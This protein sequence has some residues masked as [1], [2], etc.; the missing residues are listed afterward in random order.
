[1]TLL[2]I[3]W[4]RWLGLAIGSLNV[5]LLSALNPVSAAEQIRLSYGIFERTVSIDALETYAKTG[6]I[7]QELSSYTENLTPIQLAQFR[8]ILTNRIPLTSVE[9]SQFLYS[10]IGQ[11]LLNRLAAIIETDADESGFYGIR[12]ALILAAAD[13][14]GLTLLNILRKFPLPELEVDLARGQG[15]AQAIEI[16]VSQTNQAVA[17]INQQAA[18][19]PEPLPS[20]ATTDLQQSGPARWQQETIVLEDQSR[21]R[22][23]PVDLYLPLTTTSR[24][25]PHPVIVISHG[26]GSDR[27]SFAYLAQHLASYGFVVAVPEHPGSSAAQLQALLAGSANQVTLPSEFIDRPLDISYLLDELSHLANRDPTW[28]GRLNLE[29]VGVIGQSFGGYTALALAGAPLQLEQLETDCQNLE[30]SLNASLLLQCVALG[31]PRTQYDLSDPRIKAAIAIN[32]VDSS[33]LGEVGLSQIDIPVMIVSGSDDT[34][35]PALSEQ[36]QPFSWLTT[37]NK[38]LLLINNATHFSAISESP[39]A[40][41]RVPQ[42]VIGPRPSVV[43]N[44]MQA[45]S[46]AFAKNHVANQPEYSSY[47]SNAYA[48]AIDETPLELSLVQSLPALLT[49]RQF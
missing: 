23:I 35:A 37:P 22:I 19:T 39:N 43:R 3:R 5:W 28:Q 30:D 33:I 6:E 27:T 7:S 25:A 8:Q 24:P 14:D 49:D 20:L 46:V 42:Q 41:I 16:F 34:I 4:K 26:L 47:L 10:P 36:I 38:Y 15:I 32:P 18:A 1:M 29:Q 40:V 44:Y 2:Q 11:R 45:F 12:A 17:Q 48:E 31:L 13:P 21:D 9:V